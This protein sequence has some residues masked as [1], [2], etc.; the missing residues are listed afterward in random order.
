MNVHVMRFVDVANFTTLTP[1]LLLISCE[2]SFPIVGLK[3][4]SLP[5]LA[6]KSNKIFDSIQHI[7]RIHVLVIHRTCP[8]YHQFYLQLGHEHPEQ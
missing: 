7:Y 6:L 2:L 5:T 8:S 3:M 4:S 1:L